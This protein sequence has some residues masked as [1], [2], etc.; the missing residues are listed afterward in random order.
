[1]SI[2]VLSPLESL[3]EEVLSWGVATL[4]SPISLVQL[5]ATSRHLRR[6]C[7]DARLWQGFFLFHKEGGDHH[8]TTTTTATATTAPL[9][10][11]WPMGLAEL[12][13][14]AESF[15]SQPRRLLIH[16]V[17]G[18]TLPP[19]RLALL[20]GQLHLHII[21]RHPPIVAS[22]PLCSL[23]SALCSVR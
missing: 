12:G 17:A 15:L 14:A 21:S 1:M 6:I 11:L 8:Q 7:L 2:A 9:A 4:L 23:L 5:A 10:R 19:Q 13:R 20:Y 22:A 3:P 18:G 16:G